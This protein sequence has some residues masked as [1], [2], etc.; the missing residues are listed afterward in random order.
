MEH[1]VEKTREQLKWSLHVT[2]KFYYLD[3]QIKKVQVFVFL[4]YIL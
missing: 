4:K 1:H 3:E 2:A